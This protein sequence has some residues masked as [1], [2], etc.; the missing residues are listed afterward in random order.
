AGILSG[1][2][3]DLR[4][5]L[6]SLRKSR[7]FTAVTLLSLALG[8]GANSAI[9]GL[10]D[11]LRLRP[12]PVRHPEELALVQIKDRNW[13]SG[14]FQG[15]HSDLTNPLWVEIKAHQ[16]PFSSIG[17]WS[18]FL[19][20]TAPTGMAKYARGVAV[21]GGFFDVIGVPPMLGRGIQPTDDKVGCGSTAA[22]VS[23]DYWQRELGGAPAAL[24]QR[25]SLERHPF[26]V[27]G[28]MPR[29]FHG[30]DVGHTFD[31]AIPI[32]AQPLVQERNII[33]V[34]NAWWLSVV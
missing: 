5:A 13:G 12:L 18:D 16:E 23:D 22:V 25:L 27:V 30:L 7:G 24:G 20:N 9:F 17:A 4:Y 34:R 28:V 29:G 15:T 32:C 33:D 3:Q 1:V 21:S 26:E 6:R 2:W 8:I 10:V 14:H 31:V 11:A 19:V